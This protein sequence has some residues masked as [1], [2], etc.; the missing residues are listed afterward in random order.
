MATRMCRG[1]A[2][3]L[4]ILPSYVL[5]TASTLPPRG[6]GPNSGEDVYDYIVVGSGPGGAPLATNLAKAGYSVLL[7][8]A[9]DDQSG[10]ISTQ[11]L[12]IG[13]PQFTNRWDFYV[14]HFAD[15][16]TQLR[17][18][19]LTWQRADGSLWVGN[20]S[21]APADA[22]LLGIY[23][24]RG[25]TLGGSSV[26]NAGAT[27]L[28]SRSYWD[29]IGRLTGD[30]SWNADNIRNI[31]KRIEDN[32]YLPPGT[33]GHGFNGYFD[34]NGNNGTI[35]ER[36]PGTTA[37]LGA[38][39]SELG[40]DPADTISLATRDINN[41]SPTRD[42]TP[43]LYG[44]PVHA[45]ETWGRFSARDLVLSTLAVKKPNGSPRHPLTLKTHALVSKVLFDTKKPKG[46]G[47]KPRAVGVEYL[48]G[49][50]LYRAD[51]RY[52]PSTSPANPPVRTARARKEVILSAGVFNT[53]Q[54]LQLSGV[55]PKSE[56]ARLNIPL[57]LDLPGV[58]THMTDNQE[59]PI[60]GLAQQ[61]FDTLP[62]PYDPPGLVCAFGFP[63]DPCI[64]LWRQGL[65]PYARASLN[66]N[67]FTLATNHSSPPGE[68]DVLFFAIPFPFRGYWRFD[69]VVNFPPDPPTT[70]GISMVKINPGNRAGTVK[71]K[72][73]DPRDTPNINFN[74]FS[75]G[76][77]R[78][79]AAMRE[80]I[81]F[82]RRAYEGVPAPYG[83]VLPTEPPLGA[84]VQD[85]EQWIRE[86]SFGHHASGT[87]AIG[88]NGDPFA[89][90]DSKF[91]VR[92]IDGL[93]VVD[94]SAF[95]AA[96]GAFPV[97]STFLLSEK[98]SEDILRDA[99]RR[100]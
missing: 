11:I 88:R 17:T 85:E 48:E 51:P 3:L 66:T 15:D 9:G 45:N 77:T 14:R 93:R 95:P 41:V 27:I 61:P 68:V 70:F 87:C 42:Q 4:L 92:G 53:P 76:A 31:F 35:W 84:S 74:I 69:A 25:A 46:R 13:I 12:Q 54:I 64:D 60:V 80:G 49:Q 82:G 90:L 29:S 91:R 52:S 65:G 18:N 81:N 22:T 19:H 71:L 79:L 5:S 21:A 67:A 20:G 94:G 16:A 6:A 86:Q 78:D 47:R 72:S 44:L 83:P 7:L 75:E 28:P 96:P 23:Y 58:G 10:D 32:H 97:T 26:I 57:V 40:G 37:I 30:R 8:E 62:S 73:T 34:T 39:V 98:A 89:V 33:P 55:G 100:V 36:A 99:R 50:S 38:M 24:P 63:G 43:G 1:L 59:L 56:L 2:A